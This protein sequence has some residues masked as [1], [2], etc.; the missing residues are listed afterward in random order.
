MKY[1]MT[2]KSTPDFLPLINDPLLWKP[3]YTKFKSFSFVLF[4]LFFF[5]VGGGG[6]ILCKIFKFLNL[7]L[8]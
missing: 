7:T 2:M 8:G 3:T 4:C 6:L 1:F 5:G